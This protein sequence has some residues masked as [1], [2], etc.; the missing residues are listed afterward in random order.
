MRDGI[1]L[2]MSV[3]EQVC[4]QFLANQVL[5]MMKMHAISAGQATVELTQFK[6]VIGLDPSANMVEQA[7]EGVKS[8]LAGLD[9][10]AQIEFHQSSAEELT[11]VQDGSVD[12]LTAGMSSSS[13][14]E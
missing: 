5:S 10:S 8:H 11:L 12:L 4:L 9:L 6:R 14:K 3:V 13:W 1:L 7:R 2:L